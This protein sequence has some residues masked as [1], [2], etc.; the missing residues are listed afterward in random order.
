MV[1]AEKNRE[2]EMVSTERRKIEENIDRL[3]QEI[4]REEAE[5]EKKKQL[6]IEDLDNQVAEKENRK[7]VTN[8]KDKGQRFR[9]TNELATK[10]NVQLNIDE[11]VI[12]VSA[13]INFLKSTKSQLF[14]V[15]QDFRRKKIKW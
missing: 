15:F 7:T 14:F 11:P 1:L 13:I 9:E 4:Q 8:T 5:K 3:S 2:R 10:L 6:F 12:S